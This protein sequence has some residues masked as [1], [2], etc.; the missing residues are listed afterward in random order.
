MSSLELHLFIHLHTT[1]GDFVILC[2]VFYHLSLVFIVIL[3]FVFITHKNEN[4]SKI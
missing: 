4:F 3:C 1:E 2:F